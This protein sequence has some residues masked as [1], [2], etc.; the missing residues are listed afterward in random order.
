MTTASGSTGTNGVKSTPSNTPPIRTNRMTMK[1]V[2]SGRLDGPRRLL[3]HGVDGVGKSTFGA[4][5]PKPIFLGT[6]DGTDHLDVARFPTP[7]TWLD[8]LD[9][10][11]TLTEDEHGHETLVVD[12]VDW[13][14]PMLWKH[15]CTEANVQT[16]EEVGGGYGKGFNVALDGWRVFMA[17]LERMQRK[18]KMHLILIAH[19]FIKP[20]KN[21][22]GDDF[23]RYIL[24]L[25]E[26][27]AAV[28]REWC[29]G[30]YFA[31]YETFAVKD[32]AKRVRGVSTGAR[33]LH[34]QRTAAYDAKDRYGLPEEIPLSWDEFEKAASAG[35]PQDVSVLKAEILRKADELGDPL[36]SVIAE[37]VAKAGDNPQ[38]LALINNKV[39]AKLAQKKSEEN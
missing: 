18:R 26:K 30:V 20:F 39:N 19:S 29:K 37:T 14:E 33:L 36:K 3:I 4:C 13:A 2:V 38:S 5:A 32:K 7:E 25:N 34:T 35:A 15:V 9:A 27:A 22:L 28:L 24:K 11:N 12:S 6:E 23:D 31:N 1:D 10:I 8:C 16:I 21:P 17:A